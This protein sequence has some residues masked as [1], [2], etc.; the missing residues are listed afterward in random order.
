MTPLNPCSKIFRTDSRQK[1]CS[2]GIFCLFFLLK[3]L[4]SYRVLISVYT[5]K[6]VIIIV[7]KNKL[8]HILKNNSV[9]VKSDII[10]MTFGIRSIVEIHRLHTGNKDYAAPLVFKN[11]G[12]W[13][14]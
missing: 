12:Q 3:C 13:S 2:V 10:K 5:L 4:S 14:Y 1:Y 7:A 8:V 9:G 6:I 11:Y